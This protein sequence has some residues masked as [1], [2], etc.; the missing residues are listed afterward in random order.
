MQQS[1]SKL[2]ATFIYRFIFL[3]L[4]FDLAAINCNFAAILNTHITALIYPLSR[5]LRIS[6]MLLCLMFLFINVMQSMHHHNHKCKTETGNTI[7]SAIKKCNICD[8]T[9][10]TQTKFF[11]NSGA[12]EYVV[13]VKILRQPCLFHIFQIPKA[14]IQHF[15]NKGPPIA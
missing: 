6:A 5:T 9:V 3:F 7:S 10:H 11:N 15:S 4:S 2:F 12:F 14:E 13:P 1:C 8:Y